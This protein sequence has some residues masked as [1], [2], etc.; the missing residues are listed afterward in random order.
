MAPSGNY[1][2]LRVEREAVHVRLIAP[3]MI[4]IVHAEGLSKCDNL[5]PLKREP[6]QEN[7]SA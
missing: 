3:I 1:T 2:Q 7:G 4:I 5:L 6:Q